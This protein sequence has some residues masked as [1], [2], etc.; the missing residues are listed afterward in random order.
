MLAQDPARRQSVGRAAACAGCRV[1]SRPDASWAE[2]GL[3]RWTAGGGLTRWTAGA[4]GRGLG[5]ASS[6]GSG[7]R[8]G[9]TR[10]TGG[11]HRT[12]APR[13]RPGAGGWARV[14]ETGAPR[15]STGWLVDGGG[16]GTSAGRT[17]GS[18]TARGGGNAGPP[19]RRLPDFSRRN[20]E[21][22]L[23]T[24]G[25]GGGRGWAPGG[26]GAAPR[27]GRRRRRGR[28]C[29]CRIGGGGGRSRCRWRTLRRG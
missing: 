15:S 11:A 22:M 29:R 13:G 21:G 8:V 28:P 7:G 9:A 6:R 23:L 5:V 25:G 26:G 20:F 27:R 17:D 16:A 2:S 24:W 1:N 12:G 18:Q 19:A 14:G 3:T 4:S 10:R